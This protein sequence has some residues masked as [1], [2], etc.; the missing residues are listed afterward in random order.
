MTTAVSSE[1]AFKSFTDAHS[2][3]THGEGVLKFQ[4]LQSLIMCFSQCVRREYWYWK[5]KNSIWFYNIK[6]PIVFSYL[7]GFHSMSGCIRLCRLWLKMDYKHAGWKQYGLLC[8]Q[9]WSQGVWSWWPWNTAPSS[10]DTTVDGDKRNVSL[11]FILTWD[12]ARLNWDFL[13]HHIESFIIWVSIY[14]YPISTTRNGRH[15]NIFIN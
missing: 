14:D 3:W 15:R 1:H 12:S 6:C 9:L 10:M 13:F 8:S 2:Y 5:D 11:T 4:R 7:S